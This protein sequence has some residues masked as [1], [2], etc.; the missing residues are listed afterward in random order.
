MRFKP[1]STAL[2]LLLAVL[3]GCSGTQIIENTPTAVTV[4]YDGT[5]TM[6]D[7]TAAANKACAARGKIAKV[8]EAE[9]RPTLIR[10]FAHFDCVDK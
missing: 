7:A 10:H 5:D 3:G 9:F 8:R 1:V 6:A 2:S 4:R